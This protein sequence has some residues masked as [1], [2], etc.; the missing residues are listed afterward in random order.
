MRLPGFEDLSDVDSINEVVLGFSD[1]RLACMMG[2]KGTNSS[3][4]MPLCMKIPS[5]WYPE[6][7]CRFKDVNGL[8]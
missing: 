2:L 8:N 6:I 1:F 7:L 5:D 3:G 4:S